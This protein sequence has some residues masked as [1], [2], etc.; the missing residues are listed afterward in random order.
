MTNEELTKLVYAYGLALHAL[1]QDEG[2]DPAFSDRL[3][4]AYHLA[5][6]HLE[7]F[8]LALY[9][10][11]LKAAQDDLEVRVRFAVDQQKAKARVQP[12]DGHAAINAFAASLRQQGIPSIDPI[13]PEPPDGAG[14]FWVN[15]Y[16]DSWEVWHTAT[17]RIV[18]SFTTERS[19]KDFASY[20]ALIA[21]QFNDNIA[22][23]AYLDAL[24]SAITLFDGKRNGNT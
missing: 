7:R 22:D 12:Y 6:D 24:K 15:R 5:Q 3:L 17:R 14:A 9:D 19:A 20:A 11:R 2:D 21:A 8:A 16:E 18:C 23:Q 4:A 13:I 10:R 1:K